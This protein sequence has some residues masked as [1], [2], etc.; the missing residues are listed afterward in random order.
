MLGHIVVS[1]NKLEYAKQQFLSSKDV[2]YFHDEDSLRINKNTMY[3]IHPALT[4][5]IEKLKNDNKIMHFCG[6]LIGK[7]LS[8]KQELLRSIFR[9]KQELPSNE[10][11]AK[12]YRQS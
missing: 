9:D 6:F 2:T 11:V 10:F 8:V 1:E 5:S 7:E 4:K 3:L 12:Y